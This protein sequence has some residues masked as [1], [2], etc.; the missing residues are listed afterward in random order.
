MVDWLKEAK[1]SSFAEASIAQG[2]DDVSVV[3]QMAETEIDEWAHA[4]SMMPGFKAKLKRAWRRLGDVF[5]FSLLLP[6]T[7]L[8]A[9][10]YLQSVFN[11]SSILESLFNHSHHL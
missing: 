7:Q 4:V 10:P 3:A 2:Y 11:L 1:L 6:L 9:R 8:I 5:D